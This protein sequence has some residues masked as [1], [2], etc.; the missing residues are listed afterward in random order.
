MLSDPIFQSFERY[1]SS[2]K[3]KNFQEIEVKHYL[4]NYVRNEF[5]ELLGTSNDLN[6][7]FGFIDAIFSLSETD[8][9]DSSVP[10]ILIEDLIEIC[11][12]DS[13][14][15][16]VSYIDVKTQDLNSVSHY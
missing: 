14:I 1:E 16:L 7:L 15:P 9:I 10:F 8:K 3:A 11:S 13:L 6:Q 2:L 4:N 5:F 12:L